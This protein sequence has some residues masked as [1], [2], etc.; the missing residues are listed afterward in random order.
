MDTRELYHF[1]DFTEQNYRRLLIKA[2]QKTDTREF[3]SYKN[4]WSGTKS[5]IWR[6]DIDCSVHRALKMARIEAEVGVHAVYFVMADSSFYN[7]MEKDIYDRLNEIKSLGHEIGIHIDCEDLKN[8]PSEE[9]LISRLQFLK[10]L[11][12]ELFSQDIRTFSFHNP[13]EDIM[14]RF[15]KDTYAGLYNAYSA[16]IREKAA[17]CSDSNGYWRFQRLE[18]FLDE[19]NKYP[20]CVLTHPVWWT[21]EVLSPAQRIERAIEGR[22]QCVQTAYETMLQDY[23]RLNVK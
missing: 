21:P 22:K 18:D 19:E 12:E 23:G 9:N 6:H 11:Y 16:K 8:C 7:I 13:T 2:G 14:N 1:D 3:C 10:R 17:Y 4:I 20:M 15:Y 5:I